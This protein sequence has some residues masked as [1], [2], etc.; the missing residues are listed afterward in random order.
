MTIEIDPS[1]LEPV[2][3][4]DARI[5][6]T[7]SAL[8]RVTSGII[9]GHLRSAIVSGAA[10]CGKTYTLEKELSAAARA[11]TI[12]YQTIKG[13][14]SPIG[15]YKTLFECQR[16]GSVLLI[17]D[18]DSV[19]EDLDALNLLKAALDTGYT[20]MVHWN[21]ESHIL[22]GEGLERQ[23]EF[24]GAAMFVTNIDFAHEVNRESKMS[25]H[26]A[27]LLDRSIYVDLGIH[28]KREVLVRIGQVIYTP[29]FLAN[30]KIAKAEAKEMLLWLEK[31]LT[32]LRSVSIRTILQLASLVKTDGHWKELAE[33]VMLKK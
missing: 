33:V 27:A 14:M 26:Y 9:Q 11:G 20:R 25:P 23:F 21:K 4:I 3:Q 22:A 16:E 1:A 29:E 2:A 19:F 7:F 10:G 32:K 17:D 12:N 31:N 18:C 28:S 30:N 5:K 8:T 15:L 6:K 13:S 24:D